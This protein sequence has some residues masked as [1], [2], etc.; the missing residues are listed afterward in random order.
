MIKM[1]AIDTK[2]IQAAVNN[3]RSGVHLDANVNL[4]DPALQ[5]AAVR[6]SIGITGP[7]GPDDR[8]AV[9]LAKLMSLHPSAANTYIVQ[10]KVSDLPLH[11]ALAQLVQDYSRRFDQK[12]FGFWPNRS[13]ELIVYPIAS[14]PA[15]RGYIMF[16][17]RPTLQ[18]VVAEYVQQQAQARAQASPDDDVNMSVRQMLAQDA[19]TSTADRRRVALDERGKCFNCSAPKPRKI[20]CRVCGYTP[21]SSS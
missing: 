21:R 10:Q 8:R 15:A 1:S 7:S 9:T 5:I 20:T 16:I 2:L 6:Y 14:M 13:H 17:H 4:Q 18:R 19:V 3:I 12:G 11:P